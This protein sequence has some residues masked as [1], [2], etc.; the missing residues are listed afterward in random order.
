MPVVSILRK[1]YG[2]FQSMKR[3]YYFSYGGQEHL[4]QDLN[5]QREGRT[6]FEAMGIESTKTRDK[7]GW[8]EDKQNL[9]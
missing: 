7:G 1:K 4:S 8:D 3:G 5:K 6:V 9:Y 2:V